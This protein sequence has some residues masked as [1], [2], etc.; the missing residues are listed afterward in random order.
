MLKQVSNCLVSCTSSLP[1]IQILT[2]LSDTG[3]EQNAVELLRLIRCCSEN[4]LSSTQVGPYGEWYIQYLRRQLESIDLN[5]VESGTTAIAESNTR[6]FGR[7][8]TVLATLV[9]LLSSEPQLSMEDITARF[10]ELGFIPG[11]EVSVSTYQVVFIFLGVLT[12]L[13]DPEV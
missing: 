8:Y 13:F 11:G 10:E 6:D 9:K 12:M 7:V 3:L 2:T 5:L 1:R 4:E